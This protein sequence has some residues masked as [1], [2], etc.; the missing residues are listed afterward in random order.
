MFYT[1]VLQVL[2]KKWAKTKTKM[3]PLWG[4]NKTKI[5]QCCH[6]DICKWNRDSFSVFKLKITKGIVWI[7]TLK[8]RILK[9]ISWI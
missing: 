1:L 2:L 8:K 6:D 5:K 7:K 4:K 3:I 9:K